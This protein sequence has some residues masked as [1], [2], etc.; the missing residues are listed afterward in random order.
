MFLFSEQFSAT[1]KAN[2][3]TQLA[4]WTS[5]TTKAFESIEKIVE[6]NLSAAK[7]SLE[8]T[9][10]AARQ[11]LATKDPKEWLNLA[12]A[13][14]QPTAEKAL[15]YSRHLASIATEAHAEFTKAAEAQVSSTN[16]KVIELVEEMTKNAP[17]GSENVV[18]FVKSALGNANAGYEQFS[19]TT[20]QAVEVMGTNLN[21]AVTQFAQ[22]VVKAAPPAAKK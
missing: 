22:P 11:L 9:N 19:K 21:T 20:K 8:E 17:V 12:T 13:Q 1:S 14:S 10:A 15:A 5:L 2:A 7:T 18:A 6:L 3:E 16:R 4:V